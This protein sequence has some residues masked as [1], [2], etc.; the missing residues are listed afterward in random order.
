[1]VSARSD[2]ALPRSDLVSTHRDLTSTRSN[3]FSL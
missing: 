3:G 2:L 1:M